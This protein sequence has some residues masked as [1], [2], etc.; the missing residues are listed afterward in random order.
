[1][2]IID[3]IVSELEREGKTTGRV[4][5]RIPEDKLV[6]KPTPK[7]WSIGQLGLHLASIPGLVTR[8]TA[9]GAFELPSGGPPQAEPASKAEVL[10]TF[11]QGLAAAR[12]TLQSMDD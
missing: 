2:P 4:L 11:E 6:W 12:A 7:A 5:E 3:A 1:M 9:E 8:I 10:E